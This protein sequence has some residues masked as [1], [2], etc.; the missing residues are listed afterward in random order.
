MSHSVQYDVRPSRCSLR[1]FS[2]LSRFPH[3]GLY[4]PLPW[5]TP[6]CHR[7]TAP[8]ALS[9]S[10]VAAPPVQAWC[11]A[12]AARVAII[13]DHVVNAAAMRSVGFLAAVL[14]RPYRTAELSALWSDAALTV[15]TCSAYIV[16]QSSVSGY[17]LSP[18][19]V[20]FLFLFQL[21]FYTAYLFPSPPPDN[22]LL[23]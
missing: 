19:I 15:L 9:S 10:N 22:M 2:P 14:C 18:P 8:P 6:T 11:R 1:R 3:L 5:L 17:L 13:A 20:L 7:L 16:H 12:E 21:L 4:P 23:L